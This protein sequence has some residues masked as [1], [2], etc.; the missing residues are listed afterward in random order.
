MNTFDQSKC[1]A[2]CRVSTSRQGRS[3]LG[4]EAQ[5]LAIE[6]FANAEGIAVVGSFTEIETGKGADALDRRPQLVAA[7]AEARRLRCRVAVAK[8]DRLSRDVAFISSLMA[9]KVLFFVADLGPDVDPFMLH[10]YAALAEKERTM[11][12]QR[13]RD[14]LRAAK[15]RGVVLGGFRG[16]TGTAAD[17]ERARAVQAANADRR[18]NDLA[19]TIEALRSEGRRSLRS[20][21]AELNAR[22]ITAA[23]GGAWTAAQIGALVRRIDHIAMHHAVSSGTVQVPART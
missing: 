13:T 19:P 16:R 4:L 7:L 21:A 9:Q 3:G 22:G 23:M 17:C 12:S 6:R 1:I 8:L 15:E 18:A 14:A 5:K 11:I 20:I 10:I 2:Y